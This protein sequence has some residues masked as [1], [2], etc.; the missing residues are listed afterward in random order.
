MQAFECNGRINEI[1]YKQFQSSCIQGEK[2]SKMQCIAPKRDLENWYTINY[3][4][5][6]WNKGCNII[7]QRRQGQNASHDRKGHPRLKNKQMMY[8]MCPYST[9]LK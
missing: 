6:W 2:K 7:K 5:W 4:E 9:L 1:V 3:F 8:W